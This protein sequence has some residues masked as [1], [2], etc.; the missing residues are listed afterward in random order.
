MFRYTEDHFPWIYFVI[1]CLALFGFAGWQIFTH[2]KP[3]IAAAAANPIHYELHYI[4]NEEYKIIEFESVNTISL[5]NYIEYVT[6]DNYDFNIIVRANTSGVA[7][8]HNKHNNNIIE[9][10]S[11]YNII[12]VEK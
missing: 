4:D 8:L 1:I 2:D 10:I 12:K 6:N 3:T 5:D 11:N 9:I 7:E